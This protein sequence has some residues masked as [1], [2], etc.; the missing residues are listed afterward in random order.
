MATGGRGARGRSWLETCWKQRHPERRGYS[1]L[2]AVCKTGE[3][4]NVL[5]IH[6]DHGRPKVTGW[7]KVGNSSMHRRAAVLEMGGHNIGD[8]A[9]GHNADSLD[10]QSSEST[11]G[12]PT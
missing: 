11:C 9:G 5:C 10:T 1:W 4:D 7:R 3:F 8:S 12:S 6:G 2:D